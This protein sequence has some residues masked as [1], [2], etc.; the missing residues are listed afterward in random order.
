MD[1]YSQKCQL[2]TNITL[3]SHSISEVTPTT[4]LLQVSTHPVESHSFQFHSLLF[5][6]CQSA[7]FADWVLRGQ[8][9]Q[10]DLTSHQ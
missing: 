6:P 4:S 5:D 8:I 9:V 3:Y 7:V 1:V 10:K 2:L